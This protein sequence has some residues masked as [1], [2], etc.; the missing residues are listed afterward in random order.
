MKKILLYKVLLLVAVALVGVLFATSCEKNNSNITKIGD[1]SGIDFTPCDEYLQ[2]K[3]A[4]V[5]NHDSLVVNVINGIVYIEHHNFSVTCGVDTVYVS[6]SSSINNDTI[7]VRE[8]P[9]PENYNSNCACLISNCF[10][11][12]NIKSGTYVLVIKDSPIDVINSQSITL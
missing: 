4:G 10:Q 7:I 12:R 2:D 11:I 1:V 3:E 9:Y 6:V 8:T 5:V